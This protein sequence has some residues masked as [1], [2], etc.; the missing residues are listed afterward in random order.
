M[1]A[2]TTGRG[3]KRSRKEEGDTPPRPSLDDLEQED[4]AQQQG[5]PGRAAGGQPQAVLSHWP[6][7]GRPGSGQPQAEAKQQLTP[8]RMVLKHQGQ[9][10]MTEFL[11]GPHAAQG[12]THQRISIVTNHTTQLM[13][14]S[15]AKLLSD[16]ACPSGHKR[17]KCHR[18]GCEDWHGQR[19]VT[20]SSAG[21][22]RSLFGQLISA[23]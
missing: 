21:N 18:V 20:L 13:V 11:T 3:R 22:F 15:C 19:A 16:C 1:T 23:G 14:R 12:K 7:P 6:T 5:T 10:S 8:G 4:R 9:S 17:I 2:A